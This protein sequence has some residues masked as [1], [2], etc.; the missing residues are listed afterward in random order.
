MHYLNNN[1]D[2]LLGVLLLVLWKNLNI[3]AC[4][5]IVECLASMHDALAL[6]SS[7]EKKIGK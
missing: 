5:S 2:I 1:L 4:N 3:V 7:T 6:I